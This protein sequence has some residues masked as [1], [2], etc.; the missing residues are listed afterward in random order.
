MAKQPGAHSVHTIAPATFDQ[1]IAAAGG[2]SRNVEGTAAK[3]HFLQL[4]GLAS[5]GTG[6]TTGG[7]STGGSAP[8]ACP[9]DWASKTPKQRLQIQQDPALRQQY[10]ACLSELEPDGAARRDMLARL[11]DALPPLIPPA[12]AAEEESKLVYLSISF[13]NLFKAWAFE[14]NPQAG[15]TA[16]NAFGINAIW[17]T[18]G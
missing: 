8:H 18:G 9:S 15:Y 7:S 1:L 6:G 12:E 17:T 14:Y 11:W 10:A 16:F 2:V 13:D 3:T 4:A 5:G